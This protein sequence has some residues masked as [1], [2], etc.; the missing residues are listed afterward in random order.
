MPAATRFRAKAIDQNIFRYTWRHTKPQQIWILLVVLVSMVPLFISL[1]LPKQIV[2]GPIQGSGYEDPGARLIYFQYSLPVPGWISESGELQVFPGIELG[3]MNALFALSGVFLGFVV[4]NGLFKYYINI[5]KGRLGERMLRRMRYELV[6]R[7]LRFPFG[8]FRRVKASEVATMVKDELQPLGGFTGEAF[9]QPV[10][11]AG[12]AITALIFI[13]VQSLSLGFLTL[14][15]LAVQIILIPR[16]RRRLLVLSKERQLATRD[17]SGR[18]GE[19]VDGIT[20]VH[21]NDTSNYERADITSRLGRIF[22]IRYAIFR[23]KFIV[24]FIN[25]FLAQVTP[26]LFY[27]IGGYFAIRGQLDIGQLV[28]VIAAYKELPSPIKELI[29]WDQQ[30]LDVQVKYSQVIEQFDIEGLMEPAQQAFPS[31]PVAPLAGDIRIANVSVIDDSGATLLDQVT[32]RIRLSEMTAVIGHVGGGAEHF[33]EL[34]ARLLSASRGRVTLSDRVIDDLPE[35][36]TGR[37]IGYVDADTFFAQGTLRDSILYSLKREPPGRELDDG[38]GE[39][40]R[41]LMEARLTGNLEYDVGADW[42]DYQAAGAE[43]PEDLEARIRSVLKSVDLEDDIIRLGL[44]TS[45]DEDEDDDLQAR[46]LDARREFRRK[47]DGSS[48]EAFV[49]PF[50]PERYSQH[51][52]ILENLIFGSI[53]E[54]AISRMDPTSRPYMRQVLRQCG[55]DV[56]LYDIG[57]AIAETLVELFSGLEPD[58]PLLDQLN[59]MQAEELPDYQARLA[60]TASQSFQDASAEDQQKFLRLAFDYVEPQHRLGLLD[61]GVQARIVE[62]RRSFAENLPE[63]MSDAFAFYDPAEYNPGASV[64][65]NILFGRIASGMAEA[66]EQVDALLDATLDAAD[67]KGAVFQ[68]GLRFNAGSG[69]KRLSI[70]QRQKL[71][72]ARALIK[73]PDLL[74]VNRALTALGTD[75]QR[76]IIDEVL[77]RARGGAGQTFGVIWVLANPDLADRFE[78][79]LEFDKGAL[80]QGSQSSQPARDGE[81]TV[82]QP[83]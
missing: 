58:N 21:L 60:R 8:Q 54:R 83:A 53:L 13:F 26:F 68:L 33:A 36:I 48:I 41:R 24:K 30:R 1:D 11:L 15:I 47:L 55:L 51:A 81:Q 10:F 14:G 39:S 69:G 77:S 71:A 76:R 40:R 32:T 67:L 42:V 46:L 50:D 73:Q 66:V 65:D 9:V 72:L 57:R 27:L 5:F 59:L 79:V 38:H 62:A 3:R 34:L 80:T 75:G 2:N 43:G 35:W 44:R 19:I 82:A 78:T 6:D 12:S 45:I 4:I 56:V 31:E 7:V 52:S 70:A 16:L 74:I 64:Q 25:N 22:D 23:R 49:D 18:V 17:L 63:D 20:S 28:A 37:R 61:E 29:D